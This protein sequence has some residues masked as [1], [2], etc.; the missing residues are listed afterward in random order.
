M[1]YSILLQI[2]CPIN[3]LN[4][5]MKRLKD[6]FLSVPEADHPPQSSSEFKTDCI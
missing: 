4:V 2:F 5:E 1:Q 6:S 3:Y